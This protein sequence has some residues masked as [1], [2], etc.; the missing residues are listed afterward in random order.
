MSYS[1]SVP[2]GN[3]IDIVAQ[4]SRAYR[5]VFERSQLILEMALLPFVIVLASELIALLLPHG[6]FFGALLAAL[7]HILGFLI[8]GTVFVVRWHRY[9]LLGESVGGDLLPPGWGAFVIAGLKIAGLFLLGWMA[10]VVFAMLPPHGLTFPLSMIGSI[11]LGLVVM[12]LSL[13]FPAAAIEQP[14]PLR[15]A[16]DWVAG[17]YWRLFACAICCYLPFVI[18]EIIVGLIGAAFP[19]L[20][21]I[22]FEALRL[23]ISFAGAAVVA[24]MLS[25]VYMAVVGG[26][27]Q[28]AE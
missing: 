4:V 24:A 18:L 27:R 21:W 13:L 9:V 14:V 7:V 5:I 20:M 25:H 11:A 28:T 17:N 12:R 6:G 23:A 22:V 2:S 19:S 8:F 26:E 3:Q 15:T 1:S 16:W 10:L